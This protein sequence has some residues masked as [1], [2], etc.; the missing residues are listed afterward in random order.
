MRGKQILILS[1]FVIAIVAIAVVPTEPQYYGDK[2]KWESGSDCRSQYE[3][4]LRHDLAGW[5]SL[6]RTT[7]LG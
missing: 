4:G 2:R 7:D 5:G 3:H 6:Y 1:L